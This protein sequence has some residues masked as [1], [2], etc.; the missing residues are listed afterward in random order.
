MQA[1]GV[2]GRYAIAGAVAAYNYIEPFLTEDLEVLVS[3][4]DE[5]DGEIRNL[6][7]AV[8]EGRELHFLS[9][10]NPLDMEALAD[11]EQVELHDERDNP[12]L[13]CVLKAEH[14]VARGLRAGRPQ[15]LICI[16]ALVEERA[17][18]LDAPCDVLSRHG[19]DS[20][21]Q[22]F[23]SRTGIG[24]SHRPPG[25]ALTV[26]QDPRYPDI[27]DILQQ[28]A[29]MR[30]RRANRS[31]EKKIEAMEALRERLKPLKEAR[32]RRKAARGNSKS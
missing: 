6:A 30:R 25:V 2:I 28:K 20:A 21:W 9:V 29:E 24:E 27:S 32:E 8:I 5:R 15:D 31:F 13:T 22:E 4:D 10:S 26:E 23:C 11:A 7:R 14:L 1:D 3:L 16:S 18:D 17:V 12:L 19:L